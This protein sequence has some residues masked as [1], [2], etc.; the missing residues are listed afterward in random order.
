MIEGV[1]GSVDNLV[2][3]GERVDRQGQSGAGDV[4]SKVRHR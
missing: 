4:L 2:Q 1:R 3:L